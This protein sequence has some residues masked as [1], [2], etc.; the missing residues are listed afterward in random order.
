[1]AAR[2]VIAYLDTSALLK[3]YLAESGSSGIRGVVRGAV[4]A[5]TH[6]VTYAEA[7]AALA[8]ALR[9][10][11]ITDPEYHRQ[12]Q[13]LDL[14]WDVLQIISV[15]EPLVRRAAVLAHE[16]ELRGYD[17][18]QLAAAERL[19]VLVGDLVFVCFDRRLNQAATALRLRVY[20]G[21]V[22]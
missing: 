14:D 10:G 11:R 18:V 4:A 6:V 8:Q 9:T 17:S 15:D 12:M 22:G 19:S 21:H 5:C 13:R 20:E 2:E 16:H 1:M 3:L 7:G